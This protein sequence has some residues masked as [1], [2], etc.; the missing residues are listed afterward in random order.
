[1]E[2]HHIAL[3]NAVE[4]IADTFL[5]LPGAD[6]RWE[7]A[8][9]DL[10][11]EMIERLH[12]Y[13]SEEAFSAGAKLY[14]YGDRRVDMFVVLEGEVQVFLPPVNGEAALYSRY[15]TGNFT[16]EFNLLNS[17]GSIVEART[18]LPSTLLRIKRVELEH[19]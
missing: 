3:D 15:K 18:V 9:P 13:G 10:T 1:M 7:L 12:G 19:L 8:F 14:T 11:D 2:N 4:T 17:Q 6:F 16:G 5:K